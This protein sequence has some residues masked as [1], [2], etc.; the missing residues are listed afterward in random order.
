[1]IKIY[2]FK[3]YL[4]QEQLNTVANCGT[5]IMFS[6]PVLRS[7]HSIIC[8]CIN[9]DIRHRHP[10]HLSLRVLTY[11]SNIST[12]TLFKRKIENEI[13]NISE[14]IFYIYIIS[15]AVRF[16]VFRFRF[17]LQCKQ[18]VCCND[19]SLCIDKLKVRKLLASQLVVKR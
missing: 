10:E 6:N 5:R 14:I 1:M 7:C 9:L 12:P 4:I 11:L 16:L 19:F 17:Y 13:I 3:I 8:H 2:G 15:G 18:T